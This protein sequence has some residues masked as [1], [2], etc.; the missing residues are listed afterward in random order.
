MRNGNLTG[1]AIELSNENKKNK[2]KK[3]CMHNTEVVLV[4][5]QDLGASLDRENCDT[6]GI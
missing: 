1:S 6:D 2:T 4:C 5:K 3:H